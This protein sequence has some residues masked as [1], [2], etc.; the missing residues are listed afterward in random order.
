M[1]IGRPAKSSYRLKGRA[2]AS[3]STFLREAIKQSITL[4]RCV[5]RFSHVFAM[6]S[7]YTA[8]ANAQGNIQERLARWLL[9]S[10][11][12]IESDVLVMTHDFLALMLGVRRAGVTTALQHFEHR[13]VIETA[14][15]AIAV[16]DCD[17]LE[18]CA[19]GLYGAQI[20]RAHV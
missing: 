11:D 12:H 15:G 20:G 16:K 13:G 8:L 19:N 3:R 17:G 5:L 18:E 1:Q 10:Q 9:M 2:S 14:R 7:A 6:Q 4:L